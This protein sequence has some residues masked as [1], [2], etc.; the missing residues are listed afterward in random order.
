[1]LYVSDL[2]KSDG[3][4]LKQEFIEVRKED[5]VVSKLTWRKEEPSPRDLSL[6]KR[7]LIRYAPTNKIYPAVGNWI[8]PSHLQGKW[9]YDKD[10]E[11]VIFANNEYAL[12]IFALKNC[13]DV[14]TGKRRFRFDRNAPGYHK[15]DREV[16]VNWNGMNPR[17]ID[18]QVY[19]IE[20][21]M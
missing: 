16:Q 11:E 3:K 14:K 1:M 12:T 18:I 15:S 13:E 9:F 17:L 5:H 20:K 21:E 4:T 7:F 10:R 19:E 8:S 6:W 2:V